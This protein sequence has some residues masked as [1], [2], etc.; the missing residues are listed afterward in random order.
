MK[1]TKETLFWKRMQYGREEQ[2]TRKNLNFGGTLEKCNTGEKNNRI[3]GPDPQADGGRPESRWSASLR[4]PVHGSLHTTLKDKLWHVFNQYR[5]PHLRRQCRQ[6]PV[7]VEDFAG[8]TPLEV[9]Q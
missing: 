5:S 8:E 3:K 4:T 1:K 9:E 2:H 7:D 6:S